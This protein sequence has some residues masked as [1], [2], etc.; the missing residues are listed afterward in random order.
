MRPTLAVRSSAASHLWR[1]RAEDSTG[2][3]SSAVGERG[4]AGERA[5]PGPLRR[6]LT[7]SA[8]RDDPRQPVFCRA[9]WSARALSLKIKMPRYL[10]IHACLCGYLSRAS[11]DSR[12][13]STVSIQSPAALNWLIMSDMV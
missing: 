13:S 5:G 11:S 9:Y 6:Q 10:F 2:V 12:G 4:R 8:V 1:W 7:T 3:N